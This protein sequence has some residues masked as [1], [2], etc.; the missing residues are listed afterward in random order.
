MFRNRPAFMIVMLSFGL[1]A[2][3]MIA[4][5]RADDC[6]DGMKFDEPCQGLSGSPENEQHCDYATEGECAHKGYNVVATYEVCRTIGNSYMNCT[7]TKIHTVNL[8]N[9]DP[10]NAQLCTVSFVCGWVQDMSGGGYCTPMRAYAIYLDKYIVVE[11][12]CPYTQ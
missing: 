8:E 6:N 4:N 7:R 10:V 12:T 3:A 2:I 1:V 11:S 9:P 5:L